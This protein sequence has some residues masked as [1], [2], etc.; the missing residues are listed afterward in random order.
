[1]VGVIHYGTVTAWPIRSNR[2]GCALLGSTLPV[3]PKDGRI[4]GG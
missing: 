4:R 3:G 1:M 2:L